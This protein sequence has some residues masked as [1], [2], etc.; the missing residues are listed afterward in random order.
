MIREKCYLWRQVG[1]VR[2]SSNKLTQNHERCY[3]D[4]MHKGSYDREPKR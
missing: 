3:L 2:C 1:Q 4:Q